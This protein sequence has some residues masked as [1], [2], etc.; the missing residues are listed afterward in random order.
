M[1]LKKYILDIWG[2]VSYP[3]IKRKIYYNI[4][5][6]ED[7]IAFIIENK[8]SISRYGDGEYALMNNRKSGF[9]ECDSELVRRLY[10]VLNN[11][12]Q[13]HLVCLPYAFTSLQ[14]YKRKSKRAWRDFLFLNYKTVVKSTPT[15]R[16]YGNSLF[17]RFYIIMKDRSSSNKQLE[18][19]KQIWESRDVC[20]VEGQFSR[21]GEG[22][23]LR[24]NCN[25]IKRILCP[26]TN[27]FAKYD[28]ILTTVKNNVNKDV[29][30]IC[31]LGMTATVLAYDLTKSGYQ[32]LDLGHLDIEYEWMRMGVD[33]KCAISG[34]S[35]NE[36]DANIPSRDGDESQNISGAII[37][38]D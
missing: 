13:N 29:L 23:D 2:F 28:Q 32:A 18:Q 38:I 8:C 37:R 25:V 9:Q 14:P 27:A 35:V 20:L 12:V 3:F 5:S 30:I 16:Q 6:S 22:N 19:I 36:V 4:M 10:E 21:F 17:T 24:A 11:A 15:N 31:A 7:T 33:E 34:K 26:P 1:K